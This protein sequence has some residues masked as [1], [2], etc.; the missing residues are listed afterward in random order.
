MGLD[1]ARGRNL[2]D[3][4]PPEAKQAIAEAEEHKDISRQELMSLAVVPLAMPLLVGP[5]TI[6]MVIAMAEAG[7][8]ALLVLVIMLL[9]GCVYLLFRVASSEIKNE[10]LRLI[11]KRFIG[12]TAFM[13]GN[14]IMGLLTMALAFYI[15]KEGLKN[16]L[17]EL[18]MACR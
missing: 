4:T 3:S 5:G 2:I 12:P 15:F 16:I 11:V 8:K 14:R 6:S 7:N 17:P 1:M 9:S 13:I 10:R 18:I